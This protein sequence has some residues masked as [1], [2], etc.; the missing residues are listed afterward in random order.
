MLEVHVEMNEINALS[1]GS[2]R[3]AMNTCM[4]GRCCYDTCFILENSKDYRNIIES[5][6]YCSKTK[7]NDIPLVLLHSS[8]LKQ[9]RI[10]LTRAINSCRDLRIMGGLG[11]T[12]R[13][14]SSGSRNNI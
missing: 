14:F 6:F 3:L 11:A 4:I 10:T 2:A 13:F 7:M 5:V 9:G 8:F 1:G 12:K